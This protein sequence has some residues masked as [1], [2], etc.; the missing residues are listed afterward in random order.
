MAE[1]SIPENVT[2]IT[3]H[4]G[5]AAAVKSR[6]PQVPLW[7]LMFATVWLDLVFV[8]LFLMGIE[9]LVTAPG[10]QAG[11]GGAIIH[12]DYTHSL[13][14]AL[15]L[16]AFLGWLASLPWG[17]RNGI[18]IGFVSFSHWILDLLVHRPDLPILPGNLLGL[19]KLGFG[20]WRF[21]TASAAI[22]LAILTAGAYLY[23]RVAVATCRQSGRSQSIA[24]ISAALILIF[25][26]AVLALDV[27][28]IAG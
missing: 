10:A 6:E 4:F 5:F 22:E 26:L 13:V 18:V 14:G 15:L 16:S 28:G 27:T 9:T 7:A 2:M 8:P 12:A 1:A 25:G 11:Y 3:G 24:S 21:P 17:A 20:L 19:P 23:W